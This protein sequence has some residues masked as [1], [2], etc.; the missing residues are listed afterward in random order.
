[1]SDV[2]SSDEIEVAAW[3]RGRSERAIETAIARVFLEGDT[4]WK[5]KRRL[6]LSYVDFSTPLKRLTA[7]ERELEFNSAVAPGLYRAVHAVT[8][9]ADGG[10]ELDGSGAVVDHVLEMR[11]FADDDVLAADPERIDG[12]LADRLGRMVARAH[13]EAPLRAQGGAASL[14][15]TIGS[16]AQLI[17]EGAARIGH[18]LAASLIALTDAEYARQAALLE[19]RTVEGFSRRCHGDLHLGNILAQNGEPTPFDCIEFNDLLSDI[20]VQY[21]LA[22]LLMDLAFR[23]RADAAV[24]A[25]SAYLDEAART[26]PQGLCEGLAALPLMLSVRAAVRAHVALHADD[27]DLARAYAQAA[28]DLLKPAPA[29]LV[30]VGGLSGS[31]KST[32]ARLIAPSLGP[33]PGAVVLRTDEIRK[34]LW[35]AVADT[36]LPGEAYA[37]AMDDTVHAVLA[38]E[39]LKLLR[40][41]RAVALDA[42]FRDPARRRMAESLAAQAGVAF[43]GVWLQA[44]AEVLLARAAARVGDASDAD[45]AVVRAQIQAAG[46]PDWPSL[47]V[48]GDP[49]AAARVWITRH[50]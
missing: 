4:A 27:D 37:P 29:R 38:E 32:I 34:R 26:V 11:R 48:T 25:L 6:A 47:D 49:D 17:G 45:I 14:K 21:D 13:A 39:A 43:D 46:E 22:F 19:R 30:A 2:G 16:N 42:T 28:V 24:R 9:A 1:M 35:G 18:D 33:A 50:A 5:T 7:L 3:F 10:L 15:F 8:R 36:P 31:G 41:G 44:P 40:A 12:V 23:G 20:D